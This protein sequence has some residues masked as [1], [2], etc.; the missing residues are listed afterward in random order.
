MG[1]RTV[2]SVIC[3][4]SLEGGA[5]SNPTGGMD[6]CLFE[7]CML[8]NRGL[9]DGPIPP[10]EKSYPVWCVWVWSRATIN[11]YTYSESGE[12]AG[13]ERIFDGANPKG[14]EGEVAFRTQE[15][16]TARTQAQ[17]TFRIREG[18]A[19]T[20]YDKQCVSCNTKELGS[21]R[22]L[23]PILSPLNPLHTS[24]VYSQNPILITTYHVTKKIRRIEK[25]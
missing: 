16:V 23:D 2:W 21:M 3:G 5:G 13:E 9:C 20:A 22:E 18:R 12:D 19:H 11:V 1:G 14:A 10:R 24:T 6:V 25:S 15:N 17:G 7:C 4:R 8:S